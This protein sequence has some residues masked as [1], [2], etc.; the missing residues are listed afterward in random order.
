M[1]GCLVLTVVSEPAC[2]GGVSRKA[3]SQ[4]TSAQS[5]HATGP[6]TEDIRGFLREKASMSRGGGSG[7]RMRQVLKNA[8][9][10]RTELHLCKPRQG[11]AGLSIEE[12]SERADEFVDI[13]R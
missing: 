13:F 8:C 11:G 7:Q 6:R 1:N 9:I 4:L 12:S 10:F 2:N 3:A 5:N